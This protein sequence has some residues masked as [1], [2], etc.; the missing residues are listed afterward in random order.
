MRDECAKLVSVGIV[1]N[2]PMSQLK[3]FVVATAR[4][5]PVLVL[6][7]TSGSMSGDKI[8]VL[9][10]ALAEMIRSFAEESRLRAEIQVGVIT[11]GGTVNAYLPL[12]P[13]HQISAMP[14]LTA[15]GATPMGGAI[16]QATQWVEDKTLMPSRAYRPVL[17]LLSD[18]APTDEWETPLKALDTS[19]RGKKAAR[20]AMAI[21]ADADATMLKAFAKDPEAPL[22]QSHEARDIRRFF[23][24][25]TMSVTAASRSANPGQN[26]P[27]QLADQNSPLDLDF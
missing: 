18:G 26:T 9:N 25:V 5:L 1:S 23:R 22:F 6:A 15:E 14:T 4:P 27:L 20:F 8:R 10:Q 21:G 16:T 3:D 24:A 19:D 11:F 13:A 7:D 2:N 17:I 12:T